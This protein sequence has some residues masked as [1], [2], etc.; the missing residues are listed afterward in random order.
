MRDKVQVVNTW[1]ESAQFFFNALI[2]MALWY[3][4]GMCKC[5]FK[6]RW[7]INPRCLLEKVSVS[8][9]LQNR[10]GGWRDGLYVMVRTWVFVAL[11]ITLNKSDHI[12]NWRK[13]L[14]NEICKVMGFPSVLECYNEQSNLTHLKLSRSISCV[15]KEAISCEFN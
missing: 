9:W 2:D 5:Q 15:V 7:K 1:E 11:T 4:V 13:S 3:K 12:S 10:N 14:V 8:A 6:D